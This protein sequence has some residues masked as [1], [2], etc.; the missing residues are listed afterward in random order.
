MGV[1][2]WVRGNSHTCCDHYHTFFSTLTA[3]LSQRIKLKCVVQLLHPAHHVETQQDVHHLLPV[4][5][6]DPPDRSGHKVLPL[7]TCLSQVSS[8][9]LSCSSST[10]RYWPT[11]EDWKQE[12]QI[13][14]SAAHY[15]VENVEVSFEVEFPYQ[16]LG[17]P[18]GYSQQSKDINMSLVLISTVAMFFVCHTPR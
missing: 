5:D 16:I 8:H 9:L 1:G 10:S 6:V 4:L 13:R 3:S 18:K 2:G 15:Q 11:S 7:I 14:N 17:N 12:W